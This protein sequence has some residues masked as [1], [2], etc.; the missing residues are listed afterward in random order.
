MLKLLGESLLKLD[1]AL[2]VFLTKQTLVEYL[3]RIVAEESC[4]ASSAGLLLF[5]YKIDLGK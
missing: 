3:H 1:K 5:S 4:T 2:V